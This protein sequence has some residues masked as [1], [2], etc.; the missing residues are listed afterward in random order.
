MPV[1]LPP[2]IGPIIAQVRA[3][4]RA[5][6]EEDVTC[7]SIADFLAAEELVVDVGPPPD[8]EVHWELA[9]DLGACRRRCRWRPPPDA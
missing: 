3:R 2:E 9:C 1:T 7:D 8:Q 6:V 5:H 4:L